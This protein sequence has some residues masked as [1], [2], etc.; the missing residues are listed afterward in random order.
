MTPE[1]KRKIP[2]NDPTSLGNGPEPLTPSRLIL[3]LGTSLLTGGTEQLAPS[4]LSLLVQ[5]ASSL[6][7][8]GWEILIVSSGAVAA[9]RQII[10][11]RARQNRG[12]PTGKSAHEVSM[13]Q[14]QAAVGQSHLMS[15]YMYLFEDEGISVAQA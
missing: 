5:Q 13:R 9:G 14:V 8:L 4:V 1:R 2:T 10:H 11:E 3:K 7:R 15:L 12:L 6:Y